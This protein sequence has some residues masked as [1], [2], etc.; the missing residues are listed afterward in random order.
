MNGI[1]KIT[2]RIGAD[3]QAE[4]D[5]LLSAARAEAD[6]IAEKYKAQADALAADLKAKNEKAAAERQERLVS[7][8]QMESRKQALAAKQAL[9]E[10]AYEKAL[11]TLCQL[12]DAQYTEMVAELLAQ[13]APSGRGTVVFA[14]G[15][16]ER[17][18]AAAVEKA[19]QK[20]NGGKLTL[21]EETRPIR[22]GFIL[23]DDRMEVNGTFET[24]VRLQKAEISGAVA[25]KLFP[26]E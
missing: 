18:G 23:L 9:V 14:A 8:A 21:A 17:I 1:E 6:K 12:P 26:E 10:A 19:N 4:I 3:T 24:L 25:K 11:D 20:L 15:E 5:E 22:G 7:A 13:A 2:Q 16:R